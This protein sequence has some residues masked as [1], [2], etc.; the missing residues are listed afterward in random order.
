MRD[1]KKGELQLL[2]VERFCILQCRAPVLHVFPD[3]N[4]LKR[5]SGCWVSLAWRWSRTNTGASPCRTCGESTSW[6]LRGEGASSTSKQMWLDV[7]EP[8]SSILSL[9]CASL[10]PPA[11][12]ERSGSWWRSVSGPEGRS[13][14]CSI[15]WRT[16]LILN[17]RPLRCWAAG[18][19]ERWSLEQCGTR[20]V[21]VTLWTLQQRPP[22]LC[23][24]T[25]QFN[26][27]E[28]FQGPAFKV[29]KRD[30]CNKWTHDNC[31]IFFI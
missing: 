12:G 25:V 16:S 20:W 29:Y 23:C 6:R 11:G 5:P 14:T 7:L 9:L 31:C 19:A 28:C 21:E 22:N 8:Y 24:T 2:Q 4:C 30:K 10:N 26:V 1:R 13:R 17:S 18:S 15:S 27:W 3:T